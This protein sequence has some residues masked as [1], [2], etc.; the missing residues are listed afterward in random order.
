MKRQ[1]YSAQTGGSVGST[2]TAPTTLSPVAQLAE[3]QALNLCVGRSTRPGA[4]MLKTGDWC[5]G[6]TSAS[7]TLGGRS[8][9]P[10]P[11]NA[12]VAQMVER[13]SEEPGVR[14]SIPRGGTI[15]V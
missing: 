11:A 4:A 3:Q 15:Y 8:I 2:P 6:S 9:R 12:S 14:G 10:S 7:K 1:T 13:G 5:S